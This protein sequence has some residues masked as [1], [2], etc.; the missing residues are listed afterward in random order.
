MSNPVAAGG[1]DVRRDLTY[2]T[3]D[4][5]A[6]AGDLYLPAGAGPFPALVAVH[7]GAWRVGARSTFQYWGPY[8]AARGYALFAITYRLAGKDRKTYPQAVNDVC[9]AVQFLRGE[10][11]TYKIDADRLGLIGASAGAH[12]AGLAALAGENFSKAYP[13]DAHAAVSPKVKALVGVYGVYDMAANWEHFQTQMPTDNPT[14][15]FLGALPMQDRKLYFEASPISYTTFPNNGVSVFLSWG[16]ADD[17]VDSA[18]Q[19]EAFVLALK[20]AG[21]FVRGLVVPDAPH[22]WMGDPIEEAG[23]FPGYLAPRVVRFLG[24]RL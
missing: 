15:I 19:S 24:E 7:G 9:A 14:D 20:Q 21:F 11:K 13:Q 1:V 12:L 4:D 18:S 5:V 6:L 10:A 17:L 22:Y 8:L 23:S 2:A 16:T 3:H